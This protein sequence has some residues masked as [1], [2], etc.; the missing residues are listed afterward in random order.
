MT[1]GLANLMIKR[2]ST[3]FRLKEKD[4][5]QLN[6]DQMKV[7]LEPNCSVLQIGLQTRRLL[8]IENLEISSWEPEKQ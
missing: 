4:Q 6:R 5:K 3:L 1:H 7:F 8:K 2:V